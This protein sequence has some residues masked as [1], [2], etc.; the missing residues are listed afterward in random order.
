M[1]NSRSSSVLQTENIPHGYLPRH[2]HAELQVSAV[3]TAPMLVATL[4]A[5]FRRDGV[6][7]SVAWALK[8][9]TA[10]GLLVKPLHGV[11]GLA[12]DPPTWVEA[13]TAH[14]PLAGAVCPYLSRTRG[15]TSSSLAK[16]LQ[17]DPRFVG[18]T[19]AS[20]ARAL[21][22]MERSGLIFSNGRQW[23]ANTD[24]QAPCAPATSPRPDTLEY[25][26]S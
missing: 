12:S 26:L 4:P 17:D 15:Q 21:R 8:A 16:L 13:L 23:G 11:Y 10:K 7:S 25:L 3:V 5:Y 19:A 18:V 9:E 2:I 24:L 1:S 20:V 22:M 14:S 6:E